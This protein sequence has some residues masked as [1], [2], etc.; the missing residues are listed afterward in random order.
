MASPIFELTTTQG[1]KEPQFNH[2]WTESD[3]FQPP[4]MSSRKWRIAIGCDV[5]NRHS[6]KFSGNILLTTATWCL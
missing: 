4:K 5:C 6:H 2:D 1:S 3:T